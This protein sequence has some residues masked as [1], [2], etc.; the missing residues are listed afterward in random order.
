VGEGIEIGHTR[1]GGTGVKSAARRHLDELPL[2]L[3]YGTANTIGLA[4]LA[5]GLAFIA[6]QGGVAAM[7]AREMKLARRLWQALAEIDGV[8]I[9][10]EFHPAQAASQ[11]SDDASGARSHGLETRTPVL[12]FNIDGMDPAQAGS[13]LDVDFNVACRTGL[14]CAPLVHE[15]LGTAPDGTVRFSI[16]PF[17]SEA[18]V[19]AGAA[20][21]RALA[22]EVRDRS[23][24]RRSVSVKT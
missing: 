6:E 17:T 24:T 5:R 12:C 19:E 21:V 8:T 2:R 23:R 14:H 18:D 13:R 15:T 7:R 3:E 16:G 11:G 20:A 9:Y 10:A 1:A 4:G 22:A